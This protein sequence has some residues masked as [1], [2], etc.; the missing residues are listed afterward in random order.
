MEEQFTPERRGPGRPPK[1]EP[2]VARSEGRQDRKEEIK[3][4]RRRR[5]GMGRDRNKRIVIPDA[6][7]DPNYHYYV[8]N[9]TPGRIDQL[10][11]NDDY[12]IVT[13]EMLENQLR[14]SRGEEAVPQDGDGTP[15]RIAVGTGK[16]G[17]WM[18]GYVLR[19]PKE[20]HD[21]DKAKEQASLA[22]AEKAMKDGPASSASGLSS[23]DHA[24]V[25]KGHRNVIG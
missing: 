25:P 7:K 13:K 3:T 9:D 1:A 16:D 11:K 14:K 19:K 18:Y 10:T 8:A 23:A 2:A 22:D 21:E 12:D 4:A 15:A 20:F 24:Y 5:Q 6:A 17:Q